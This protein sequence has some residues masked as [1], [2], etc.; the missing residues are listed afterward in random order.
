MKSS[1]I[2]YFHLSQS[3]RRL[4]WETLWELL[5]VELMV[6]T[7][8]FK[9]YVHTLGTQSSETSTESGSQEQIHTAR[10]IRWAIH[11]VSRR[12]PWTCRCLV[13]AIAGK[14][15][16]QRRKIVSTLYL[17]VDHGVV[18][19]LEAHAWL[20][21]GEVIVTGGP[22]HERFRVLAAFAEDSQ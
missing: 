1:L 9:R 22:G 6:R 16:L 21:C 5:S 8:P 10:E 17:G 4:V 11:A 20:R 13:Q 12:L 15:M 18:K 14:R 19:N 7:R 2:T 3:S